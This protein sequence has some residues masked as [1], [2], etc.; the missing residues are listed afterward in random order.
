[1][2]VPPQPLVPVAPFPSKSSSNDLSVSRP[3][4]WKT[5]VAV[6]TVFKLEVTGRDVVVSE[7]IGSVVTSDVY[8]QTQKKILV[9]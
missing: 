4:L 2:Q 5:S 1:M 6:V 8:K 7:V 9:T 3:L